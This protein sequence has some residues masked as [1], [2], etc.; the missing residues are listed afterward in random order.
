MPEWISSIR[1]KPHL[2]ILVKNFFFSET[3]KIADSDLR[4]VIT[5]IATFPDSSDL[6]GPLFSYL[7]VVESP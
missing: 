6:F 4:S 3:L 7:N 5:Y 1:K 2:K